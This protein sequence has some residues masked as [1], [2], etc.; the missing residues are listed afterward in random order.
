MP[1]PISLAISMCLL[2]AWRGGQKQDKWMLFS[3][4]SFPRDWSLSQSLYA[5]TYWGCGPRESG[6][7]EGE[8]METRD[9]FL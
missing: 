3:E 7:R 5:S 9:V 4:P 8:R 2:Q 1:C 6:G